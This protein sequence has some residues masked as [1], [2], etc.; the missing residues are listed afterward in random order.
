MLNANDMIEIKKNNKSIYITFT[1]Y[2]LGL[3]T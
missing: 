2:R 1:F 3:R